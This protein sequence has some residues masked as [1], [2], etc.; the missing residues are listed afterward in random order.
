MLGFE[1]LEKRPIIIAIA[2]S[3]GTGKSTFFASHLADCGLRFVNAEDIA[4]ELDIGPF[5]AAETA[6][7]SHRCSRFTSDLN[8]LGVTKTQRFG[9]V[10]HREGVLENEIKRLG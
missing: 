4:L 1:F 3:D 2:G 7:V 10:G 8:V 9:D 5:A 6:A